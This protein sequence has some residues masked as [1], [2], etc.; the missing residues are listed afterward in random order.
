LIETLIT[1]Q[2]PVVLDT[3]PA[4]RG[5]SDIIR[6]VVRSSDDGAPVF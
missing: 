1:S 2:E 6:G 5:G 3:E 4:T